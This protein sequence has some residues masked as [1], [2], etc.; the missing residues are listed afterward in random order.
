MTM[1]ELGLEKYRKL[2]RNTVLRP[3]EV[4]K[5]GGH[6]NSMIGNTFH[7]L[8]AD[9]IVEYP[10][11]EIEYEVRFTEVGIRLLRSLT[12]T[13]P[14]KNGLQRVR[15]QILRELLDEFHRTVFGTI[16]K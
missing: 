14:E 8:H 16:P 1:L 12:A 9:S 6:H 13:F 2:G 5:R 11:Q 10:E 7:R 3:W 4:R 15:K